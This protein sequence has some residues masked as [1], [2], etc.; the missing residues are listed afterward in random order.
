MGFEELFKNSDILLT[1]GALVERLK[2]EY[3]LVLDGY[4]NHAVLLYTEPEILGGMYKQY[5]AIGCKYDL[6]VMLMTP[7]RKVN[8]ESLSKSSFHDKDVLAD[9]CLFLNEIKKNYGVYSDKIMIGGLL[10]CKGDAYSADNPLNIDEAYQFHSTQA[11][12]FRNQEIDFLFAGIMPEINEAIGMARA[13]ADT[14]IPYIISFMIRKDGCLIDGTPISEAIELIDKQTSTKPICY[15]T[16]CVYPTNLIQALRSD[17]NDSLV[18][19]KRF[20]GIQ[21]NASILSPE[22]LNNC[23]V[24]QQGDFAGMI[25]EMQTLYSDFGMKILG[26]CCGT[27]DRFIDALAK[28]IGRKK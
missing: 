6:P 4:I 19:K 27:N 8:Y 25:E 18:L 5:M 2:D 14:N 13:M 10:G 20:K 12:Q 22:E 9:S 3:N 21:A 26:G 17:V 16:N 15:M 7:T 23:G 11:L 1:E 24:L 28:K